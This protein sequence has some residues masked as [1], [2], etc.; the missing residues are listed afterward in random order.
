MIKCCKDD[1]NE[2]N[3]GGHR[4]GLI[5]VSFKETNDLNLGILEFIIFHFWPES[6]T[7]LCVSCYMDMAMEALEKEA[8]YFLNFLTHTNIH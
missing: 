1:D 2:E 5:S 7:P 4:R 8:L 6:S 3:F